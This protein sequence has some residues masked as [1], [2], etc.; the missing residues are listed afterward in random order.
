MLSTKSNLLFIVY[1]GLLFVSDT[2]HIVFAYNS[3]TLKPS[4]LEAHCQ[5]NGTV[6]EYNNVCGETFTKCLQ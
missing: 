3:S 4:R 6:M 1:Y 2:K 5:Y